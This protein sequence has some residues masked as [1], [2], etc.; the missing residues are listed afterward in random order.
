MKILDFFEQIYIINLHTRKDRLKAVMD[1]LAKIGIPGNST[2]LKIFPAI[3]PRTSD[4]FPNIGSKGCF[5]SHLAVLK[6]A[7]DD[8]LANILVIED[9]LTISKQFK[10]SQD[11]LTKQLSQTDWGFVYFGHLIKNGPPS[12]VMLRPFSGGIRCTHFYGVNGTIFIQLISF[13]DKLQKRSKGHPNGGPMHLDGAYSTFRKQNPDIVTLLAVPSL[14][15]QRS[16]ASDVST[17]LRDRIPVVRRFVDIARGF[18]NMIK[19]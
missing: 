1:E 12:S 6:Q 4:E 5:L 7:R 2:K 14:G 18:K 10:E 11:F 16:S 13:I 9:D 8:R 17:T 15:W 19:F 3:R